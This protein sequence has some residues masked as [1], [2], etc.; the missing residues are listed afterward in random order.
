MRSIMSIM[1]LPDWPL[2][3][4]FCF[5]LAAAWIFS[6]I[7]VWAASVVPPVSASASWSVAS[8]M[9]FSTSLSNS[10]TFGTVCSMVSC[11][12]SAESSS[13][14]SAILTAPSRCFANTSSAVATSGKQHEDG[15]GM[16]EA[17]HDSGGVGGWVVPA[18][19]FERAGLGAEILFLLDEFH[20]PQHEFEVFVL[21]TLAA[22]TAATA[23]VV[24]VFFAFQFGGPFGEFGRPFF[25]IL[26]GDVAVVGT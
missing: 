14:W 13:C 16:D 22:T 2:P 4:C 20:D 26:G 10:M 21:G 17:R 19:L 7:S 5:S 1:A 6:M 23:R 9:I 18:E 15:D 24:L 12:T 8:S 3:C 25:G 11:W